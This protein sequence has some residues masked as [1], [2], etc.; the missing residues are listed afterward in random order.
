MGRRA[1]LTAFLVPLVAGAQAPES[2]TDSQSAAARAVLGHIADALAAGNSSDA[3]TPF[4]TSFPKYATLNDY[5]SGLISAFYLSNEIEVLDE[6]DG[7]RETKLTVRWALTLTNRQ[8]YYT[9]N[10]SAELKV[11]IVRK[12]AKWKIVALEPISLFD[13]GR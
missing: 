5:F 9:E 7:A 11:Q 10:R 1:V 8:T 12:V 3:M 2:E 4:D 6:E 13:P